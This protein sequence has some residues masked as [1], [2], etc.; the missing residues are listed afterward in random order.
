MAIWAPLLAGAG[1]VL[2][3]GSF[4]GA[5]G[6]GALSFLGGE[7]ANTANAEMA[8]RQME[9]QELMS[10]TARQREVA[11]L[12]AAGLNPILSATGGGGASTPAGA[13]ATMENSVGQGVQS[14]MAAKRLDSD[15]KTAEVQR[16]ATGVAAGRDEAQRK[17]NLATE[18]KVK[19]DEITSARSADNLAADTALK[20]IS[21]AEALQRTRESEARTQ[22]ELQRRSTEAA[23]TRLRE[24]EASIAGYSAIGAKN[25][26][27]VEQS[28]LGLST[29]YIN[30]AA[31][32]AKGAL[33][34][35]RGLRE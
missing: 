26:A 2:G 17:V 5:V 30:R 33:Q 23:M 31:A 11:D 13:S 25:E 7:R 32:S 21:G 34:V 27:D 29:R 20:A 3:S 14:A 8:A 35:Y 22:T 19:Q 15:L 16:E 28:G 9:F 6:G 18:Q 10:R 1:K 4:W 12:K 24:H